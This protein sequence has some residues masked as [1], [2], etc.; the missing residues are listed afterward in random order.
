[1]ILDEKIKCWRISSRTKAAL[2]VAKTKGTQL[3]K[4]GPDNLKKNIEERQAAANTFAKNLSHTFDGMK[5]AGLSQRGMV[6]ALN[7][8]NTPTATG[9]GAWSLRQVQRCLERLTT[10]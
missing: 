10:I 3:G 9:K 8:S 4:A 6:A 7:A 5:A 1:M 2:A